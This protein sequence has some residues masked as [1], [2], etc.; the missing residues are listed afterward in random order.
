MLGCWWIELSAISI[1]FGF[2]SGD[3]GEVGDGRGLFPT[4]DAED[5]G[6]GVAGLLLMGVLVLIRFGLTNPFDVI[7]R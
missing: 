4:E 1:F 2:W 3:S 5:A 6:N 7:S